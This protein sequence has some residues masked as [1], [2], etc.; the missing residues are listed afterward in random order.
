MEVPTHGAPVAV[1][2]SKIAESRDP[3]LPFVPTTG[4][5]ERG[6]MEILD[7][8]LTRPFYKSY[9]FILTEFPI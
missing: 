2:P 3:N 9:M 8:K 5:L 1:A 4:H 6:G 7:L